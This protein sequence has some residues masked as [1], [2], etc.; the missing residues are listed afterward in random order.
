MSHP[1]SCPDGTNAH[2]PLI[3]QKKR[4]DGMHSP[5]SLGTSIKNVAVDKFYAVVTFS[6]RQ[7]ASLCRPK[8]IP[9]SGISP[10]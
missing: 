7:Y 1:P 6:Q 4:Q 5:A 2:P 10:E 9:G 3:V 8:M